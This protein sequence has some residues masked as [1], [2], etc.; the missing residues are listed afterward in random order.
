M[1]GC[2]HDDQVPLDAA[3]DY[4]L[5]ISTAANRPANA[6]MGCGAI[7]LPVGPAPQAVVILRN[8]L[9]AP[10]FANAIQNATQGSELQTMGPYYPV[11]RYFAHVSEFEGT[12]CNTPTW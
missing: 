10:D 9:P 5:V 1:Y 11:G 8:M 6:T 12:G 2:A 3:G 4:T 7:W